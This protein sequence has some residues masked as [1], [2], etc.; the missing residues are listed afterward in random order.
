MLSLIEQRLETIEVDAKRLFRLV[1]SALSLAAVLDDPINISP[2]AYVIPIAERPGT[3]TRTIGP[4]LQQ[5]SITFGVIIAVKSF[6]DPKGKKG[7]QLL[8]S[9]RSEIRQSLFGWSPD[10]NHG[11][12]ELGPGD[13]VAMKNGGIWWLDRFTT[14]T[15]E[16]STNG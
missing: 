12:V 15:Y 7:S 14:T 4:A 3:N 11:A 6:N 16:E 1:D 13:L 8:E 2:A 10:A 5:I 9:L